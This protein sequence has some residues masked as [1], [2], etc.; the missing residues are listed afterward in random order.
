MKKFF[1]IIVVSI[2]LIGSISFYLIVNNGYDKQNKIILLIKEIIPSSVSRKIRD[3]IF[4]IPNLKER[5]NFLSLQVEKYEQGLEGNLFLNNTI[6]SNNNIDYNIKEFFLPFPRLD[7][8][9]GWAA[10]KNSRRAHY[11]E[12]VKDKVLAISGVG[13]IIYFQKENL[14]K[15]KLNQIEIKNNLKNYLKSKKYELIGIRDLFIEDDYVYIS[16][17]HRDPNG[18]TINIYRAKLNFKELDFKPFFTPNEY[19]PKY[20]VFS[21]GRIETYK[22]NKILFSIGFAYVKSAAQNKNSLLGKI[23]SINKDTSKFEL[24]SIGHRNPQG[25]FYDKSRDLII[26][27]EHGPKGGDEINLNFQKSKEIPN[28]GW[29]I[30]SYGTPYSGEDFFKK[31]H[32]QYGFVEPFKNYTP[33][34]GISEVVYISKKDNFNTTKN[35]LYASSLRAGS[36]YIINTNDDLNEIT[37]EDRLF[38]KSKRIRDLEYD[39]D[40]NAFL[41]LFEF[42]PS[43]GILSLNN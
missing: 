13:Q 21:G 40:L 41:I 28:Y 39:E 4:T 11:F 15:K 42:T 30:A 17:Q 33:S 5:N 35:T 2:L 18:F 22:D 32:A 10:T 24:I 14:N 36:I 6:K 26:N 38:F 12:I 29:D 20:N 3:T 1:F 7:T 27:T 23:I 31:S 16:V 34:I 43:I 25:L 8:R 9:L 19:W 37:K